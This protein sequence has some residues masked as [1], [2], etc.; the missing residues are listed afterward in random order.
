MKIKEKKIIN[1]INI[2]IIVFFFFLQFFINIY[3]NVFSIP[4]HSIILKIKLYFIKNFYILINIFF[5]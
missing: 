5:L 2:S 4:F 1:D 3:S